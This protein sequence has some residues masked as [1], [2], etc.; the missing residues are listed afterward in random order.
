VL[1]LKK[2]PAIAR[3][4]L[5]QKSTSSKILARSYLVPYVKQDAEEKQ[6]NGHSLPQ[7]VVVVSGEWIT[8]FADPSEQ[9]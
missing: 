8:P 7:D 9:V 2:E 1:E 4:K 6:R 3:E 5:S